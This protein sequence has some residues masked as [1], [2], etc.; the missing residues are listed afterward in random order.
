MI[1][2]NEGLWMAL[3]NPLPPARRS[4]QGPLEDRS[5]PAPLRMGLVRP[6]VWW[7]RGGAENTSTF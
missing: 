3:R 4:W 1:Y 2:V 6:K 7:D 5:L